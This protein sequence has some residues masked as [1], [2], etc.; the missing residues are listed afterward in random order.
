MSKYAVTM[1]GIATSLTMAVP[2]FAQTAYPTRPITWVV[3][4]AAGGVTDTVA[5]KMA[6][7]MSKVLGQTVVVENKPGA[8]GVVGTEAVA[9]AKNDGYT[10]LYTSSGPMSILPALQAGKLSYDPV[11]SFT[12]VQGLSVA[13]QMIVATPSAP[14]S[15][16]PELIAY[17]KE[18]PNQINYGSPGVGTAQHLAGELLQ[19][20]A[21][22][23][24]THIPYKAGSNQMVDLMSG[25]IQ[26]SFEYSSVVAPYVSGGKMK[27]LGTTGSKRASAYPNA[28]TVVEAGHPG[29]ENAGWSG[30]AVPAGTPSEVVEKIA[31]AAQAALKDPAVAEYFESNAILP[32]PEVGPAQIN[33]FVASESAKFKAVVERAGLAVK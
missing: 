30:I 17:A 33:E 2:A 8:G 31:A 26:V 29:A 10:V 3:P 14:F 11:K 9:S 5:R 22:I 12:H 19:S 6:G 7:P 20:A 16:L 1:L 28:V 24:M 27:V 13:N 18:N 25:V 32:L 15:T 21:G 4:F 23:K